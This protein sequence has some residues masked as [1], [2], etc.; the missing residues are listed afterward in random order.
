MLRVHDNVLLRSVS[1]LPVL[2]VMAILLLEYYVF[3]M[4]YWMPEFQRSVEFV[5]LWR[6]FEAFLFHFVVGCVLVAYFKV[7]LTDPGY[8]TPTLIQCMKDAMQ[9]AMEEGGG[10]TLPMVSTCQKC[11]LLK[12]FRAHHCSFCNRCVL[13]MDHHCPWVA[14]CVGQGNY[15][16]FFHFVIYAFIA[17]SLCV[18]ALF[19]DFQAALFSENASHD[20]SK[21]SAMAVVGFVL[22]GALGISLL[23]FIVVHSYLLIHGATT[24]ECHE[25]GRA[26]PFNQ[27][28]RMNVNQVFGETKKDWFL[29]TTPAQKQRYVLHPAELKHLTADICLGNDEDDTLL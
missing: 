15:K 1:I 27:G 10:K 7:V 12:P 26:F 14:N 22:A 18:R 21:F 23:G 11:H 25:Y 20:A 5:V 6:L 16:F 8:V 28:W 4:E 17:L 9:E 19:G 24:I 2:M 3:M 29:P 13:K